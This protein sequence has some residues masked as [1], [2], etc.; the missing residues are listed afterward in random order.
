MDKTERDLLQAAYKSLCDMF[1]AIYQ[2]RLMGEA[3]CKLHGPAK[4]E[5]ICRAANVPANLSRA[6]INGYP[7]IH[8]I[9]AYL[10]GESK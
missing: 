8:E 2:D 3:Q 10:K 1:N 7:V 6:M 5:D 4:I 9:N